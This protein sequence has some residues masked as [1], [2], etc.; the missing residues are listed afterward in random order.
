MSRVITERS[1]PAYGW[2]VL[3]VTSLGVLLVAMGLS[4]VE[5]A[6]PAVVR[7]TQAGPDA[8]PWL[9]L[10]SL[11]ATT[12]G[13]LV[14]G[15]LADVVGRRPTYLTGLAVFSLASLLSAVAPSVEVL[16]GLRVVA[17]LAAAATITCTTPLLAAALPAH[18]R[19][20]GLGLNITVVSVAQ[21]AG[22]LAGGLLADQLGWQAVFWA[23]APVGA[24]ALLWGMVVLERTP[25]PLNPAP[26]DVAGSVLSVLALTGLVLGLSLLGTRGASDPL[27]L[28]CATVAL[29][30]GPAFVRL[31][32]RRAAPLVDP[33]LF[34]DRARSLA[35]TA[36]FAMSASRYSVVLL[37]ALYLQ[38]ARGE[39]ASSAGLQ[40]VPVAAGMLVAAPLA[41]RLN[42]RLDARVLATTGLVLS[43]A[44]LL[45]LAV[46]LGP[47]AP[48][49]PIGLALLA[50]GAGSGLFFPPNTD[51]IVGSA[52]PDRLG[53][54]NAV[55]SAVQNTG[56]VVGTALSLALVTSPLSAGDRQAAYAGTLG[57]LSENQL[58]D[59][60]GAY[61]V[62]LVVLA[63]VT[64]AGAVASLLRRAPRAEVSPTAS[65]TS[66]CSRTPRWR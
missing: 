44:G 1:A 18:L 30:A 63:A 51:A 59:V 45:A 64:L 14:L 16:I 6:L 28:G 25:R 42:R 58:A 26:F 48:Y 41:G 55:R 43:A 38:A 56:I 3:S 36:A 52:P 10:S 65:S 62:A 33:A 17:G 21:V 32:S 35:Y 4:S 40:V 15:R 54:A 61:R 8:A 60:T 29:I 46:V 13:V 47:T 49:A 34:R 12:A 22:P 23:F 39:D 27:V 53:A 31:Q 7:G 19:T 20:T 2:R 5:V 9:L 11:L 66:P 37:L 57:T 50:V 24:L